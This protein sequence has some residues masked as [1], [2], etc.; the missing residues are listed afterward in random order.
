MSKR[1]H[2]KYPL[3]LSDFNKIWIFYT[4]FREKYQISSFIKILPV[5]AELFYAGQTDMKQIVVFRNLILS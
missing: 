5:G 1:L 2:V 3:F 4:G